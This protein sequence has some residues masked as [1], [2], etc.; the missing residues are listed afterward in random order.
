VYAALVWRL[1]QDHLKQTKSQ[2]RSGGGSEGGR[3]RGRVGGGA[4]RS[5]GGGAERDEGWGEESES[6]PPLRSPI[7]DAVS[8]LKGQGGREKGGGARDRVHR[9]MPARVDMRVG[10]EAAYPAGRLRQGRSREGSDGSEDERGRDRE[11]R[12]DM[13][14]GG[15]W[16]RERGRGVSSPAAAGRLR[17]G[18]RCSSYGATNSSNLLLTNRSCY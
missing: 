4:L 3:E 5:F 11:M 16:A 10:R 15:R 7:A 9:E 2:E 12:V 17:V 6:P 13:R 18:M 1:K 14:V 8:I